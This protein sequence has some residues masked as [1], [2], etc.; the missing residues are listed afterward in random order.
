MY[1]K[2]G[3]VWAWAYAGSHTYRCFKQKYLQ[4]MSV[5]SGVPDLMR[6]ATTTAAAV[7]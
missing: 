3:V 6:A 5:L 4:Y 7:S 1:S 2:T